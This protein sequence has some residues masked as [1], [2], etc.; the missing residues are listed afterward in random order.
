MQFDE[1]ILEMGWF[2]HHQVDKDLFHHPIETT[3]Y[4]L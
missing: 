4:H 1:H 2:N 3:I